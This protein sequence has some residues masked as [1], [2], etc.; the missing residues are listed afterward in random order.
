[1]TTTAFAT[2]RDAIRTA[3]RENRTVDLDYSDELRAELV[4]LCDDSQVE[5]SGEEAFWGVSDSGDQWQVRL[6]AKA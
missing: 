4:R 5:N 1:M 3:E 2:V 6:S